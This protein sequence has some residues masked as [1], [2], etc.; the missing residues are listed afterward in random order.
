MGSCVCI[1]ILYCLSSCGKKC[2]WSQSYVQ[3]YIHR[4][5]PFCLD[6]NVAV[7]YDMPFLKSLSLLVMKQL[8]SPLSTVI[9]DLR[10]VLTVSENR[11]MTWNCLCNG[12]LKWALV[13]VWLVRIQFFLTRRLTAKLLGSL[14]KYLFTGK[15]P[16]S[17]SNYLRKRGGSSEQ[18]IQLLL[19][20]LK[21]IW[22]C[23]LLRLFWWYG[24]RAEKCS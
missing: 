18:L 14:A 23:A 12:V 17:Q 21:S 15:I 3:L 2:H 5:L 11:L 4:R 8:E 20:I 10:N 13:R 9:L 6:V 1:I 7:V 16:D 19:L 24:R 22:P